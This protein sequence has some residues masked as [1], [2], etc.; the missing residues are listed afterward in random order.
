MST[1]KRFKNARTQG[2]SKNNEKSANAWMNAGRVNAMEWLVS[3][4]EWSA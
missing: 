4:T 3:W 1:K 2:Q